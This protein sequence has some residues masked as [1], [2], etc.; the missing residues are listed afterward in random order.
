LRTTAVIVVDDK[1]ARRRNTVKWLRT[2]GIAAFDPAADFATKPVMTVIWELQPRVVIC[3]PG[4]TGMALFHPLRNMR[5]PPMVILLRDASPSPTR[6]EV[7]Y[8]DGLIVA[9]IGTP[10]PMAGLCEFVRSALS[11]NARLDRPDGAAGSALL[12]PVVQQFPDQVSRSVRS[13]VQALR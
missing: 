5:E 7:H 3:R 11:I 8:V 2:A 1:P 6:D 13:M 9:S 12:S 10:V 4:S